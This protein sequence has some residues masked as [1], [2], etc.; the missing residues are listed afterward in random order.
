[1]PAMDE[2]GDH[3]W[4]KLLIVVIISAGAHALVVEQTAERGIRIVAQ[5]VV[6][7]DLAGEGAFFLEAVHHADESARH[8]AVVDVR[9]VDGHCGE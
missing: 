8:V 6:F 2:A 1:M 4:L 9:D 3:I 7:L 5:E